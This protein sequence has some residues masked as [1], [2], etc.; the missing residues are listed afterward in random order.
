VKILRE[1]RS[2]DQSLASACGTSVV[3]GI[4][5]TFAVKRSR[6]QFRFHHGLMHRTIRKIRNLLRMSERE[7]AASAHVVGAVAG[8]VGCRGIAF[9]ERGRHGR[10]ANGAGPSSVP[11]YLKLA[12][13]IV[14]RKEDRS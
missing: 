13:P 12:V 2:F 11:Y 9:A 7:H 10:V 3:I 8:I 1:A 4:L 6:D 5:G 14:S